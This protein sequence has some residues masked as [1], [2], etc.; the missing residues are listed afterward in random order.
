MVARIIHKQILADEK[1]GK[2]QQ[3]GDWISFLSFSDKLP[4]VQEQQFSGMKRYVQYL[5][6]SHNS[7]NQSEIDRVFCAVGANAATIS[8]P[9]D[10]S[11]VNWVVHRVFLAQPHVQAKLWMGRK[12]RIH[13]CVRS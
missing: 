6:P 11:A 9:P 8:S 10:T 4:L 1:H 3:S 12:R 2:K 5:V 7:V 13:F